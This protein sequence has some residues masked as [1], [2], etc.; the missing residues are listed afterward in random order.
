MLARHRDLYTQFGVDSFARV[1]VREGELH[2]GS[3]NAAPFGVAGEMS[4]DGFESVSL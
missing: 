3:V 4:T 2:L 1:D